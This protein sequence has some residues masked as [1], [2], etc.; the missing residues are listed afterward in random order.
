MN[1]KKRLSRFVKKRIPNNNKPIELGQLQNK[2]QSRS[3]AM[4][5]KSPLPVLIFRILKNISRIKRLTNRD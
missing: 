3:G 4:N 5:K 1:N 2:K